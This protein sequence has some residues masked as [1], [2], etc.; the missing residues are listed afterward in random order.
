MTRHPNLG[1]IIPAL[2][3]PYR[4]DGT[5]HRQSLIAIVER[6]LADGADGFYVCGSTGEAFL[7]STE[8]RKAALETV[9]GAAA[10]RALVI[11]HVGSIRTDEAI[12]LARHAAGLGVD[13]MSAV[14]P[15]YYGFRPDEILGYYRDLLAACDLPMVIY[16]FPASS[17]VTLDPSWASGLLL[18]PRVAAVKHTSMDLY[19]LERMRDLRP[20]LK[21]LNGHDEVF[22]GGLA[23]GADGAIG[24][25][26][27]LLTR[28]FR[29][30][31]RRHSSGDVSGAHDLQVDVNRFIEVL[32]GAGVFPGIKHLLER[33]GIP[34]GPCRRPFLPLSDAAA[35]AV[36]GA[37]ERLQAVPLDMEAQPAG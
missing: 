8:E 34:C 10:E 32:I 9:T 25:T 20:D 35:A 7:L 24:S 1:G 19:R 5:I 30:I 12:E 13:A 18:D 2:V 11:A 33:L 31:S 22:L 16:N 14:P 29:E 6:C 15:F 36:E 37:W 17:G 27:N 26:F 21:V 4:A 28:H 3:T 23:L